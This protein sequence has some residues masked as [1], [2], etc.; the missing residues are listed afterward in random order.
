MDEITNHI[1]ALDNNLNI[2]D[3]LGDTCAY[4]LYIK[5]EI[6]L[7]IW[8]QTPGARFYNKLGI[9]IWMFD[10]W[11]R[12]YLDPPFYRRIDDVVKELSETFAHR[13]IFCQAIQ[14]IFT[15]FNNKGE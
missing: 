14:T 6:G 13:I 4:Y 8:N 7:E 1:I 12:D 9:G 3:N 11:D 2:V 15:D 5:D 10:P